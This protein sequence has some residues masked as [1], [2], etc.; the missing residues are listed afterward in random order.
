MI[1]YE[2]MPRMN[3]VRAISTVR[4]WPV[5]LTLLLVGFM[6][7]TASAQKTT[8][9]FSTQEDFAGWTD[10]K[11]G[12]ALLLAPTDRSL[13]QNT[14]NGTGNVNQAG[15][16]GTD[17]A[18]S[19]MWK[20][21]NYNSI[22]SPGQQSNSA[23]IV[24]LGDGKN[25]QI[26]VD[27][28]EP[29]K[30]S[31]TYFSLLL[32]LNY[33]GTW[34]QIKP[35]SVT[36]H[37]AYRTAA[38]DYSFNTSGLSYLSIGFIYASN[39]NSDTPFTVDNIRI[40]D[41]APTSATR[42]MKRTTTSLFTTKEDFTGWSDNKKGES[43]QVVAVDQ[44]LDQQ[45]VNGL[46]NTNHA[47][48]KGQ[49]GA[50]SVTWK[51][52]DYNAF[53]SPGQQNNHALID[54]LGDGT[55]RQIMVDYT[56]PPKGSGTYFSLLLNLNYN[57]HW[58]QI[59]P[60][61]VSDHGTYKTATYDFTFNSAGLSYL[62]VG[63][64]YVSNYNSS[65]PFMI[66]NVRL[67]TMTPDES[68]QDDTP[69]PSIKQDMA[70][71]QG[72]M[73]AWSMTDTW[74]QQTPTRAEV[75]LNGLW[76]F[77]PAFN[78]KLLTQPTADTGWGW[79]KVPGAWPPGN[80]AQQILL[81]SEIND[82]LDQ[83]G[84]KLADMQAA[85]YKRTIQVPAAW[86]GRR[87]L[88][89]FDL[90]QTSGTLYVDGQ[91]A[92]EIK[93]PGGR[94]DITSAIR[95]GQTQEL[96]ILVTAYR[97]KD[98]GTAWFGL[99]NS[100][101]RDNQ[102]KY[103]GLTGDVSLIAEP[104]DNVLGDTHVITS[105]RQHRI[106]FDTAVNPSAE[107]FR[108]NATVF[109]GD[110]KVLTIT[111][112]V[113][114]HKD[115]V[116]GRIKFSGDWA[117]PLLWDL[118]TPQNMYTATIALQSA[119]GRKLLDESTPVSFGFREFWID[120]RDFYLNGS[121]IHLRMLM[122]GSA[123]SN[124]SDQSLEGALMM[125]D[126]A[127]ADGH[128]TFLTT[129]Y[130]FLPGEVGYA[131]N[132]YR[133]T[134]QKGM[135][136]SVSLLNIMSYDWKLD[137]PIIRDQYNQ[138][139][140]YLIKKV[141]NHPSVFAYAM[142][143]N[144][145]VYYDAPNP[146]RLDG[147]YL[148]DGKPGQN[149]WQSRVRKLAIDV[150]AAHAK[151]VDPTRPVYHH[152]AGNLGDMITLNA[153]FNW[154]PIQERSDWF[155]LWSQQGVKPLMLVEYG[156]PHV[157][158][159]TSYRGPDFIWFKPARMWLWDREYAAAFTENDAY[160]M[161]ENE[162][163]S[164][165]LQ[166][167]MLHEKDKFF[168]WDITSYL[169]PQEHNFM[170]LK[171]RYYAINLPA[172]R[173]WGLSGILPW[174]QE[175]SWVM[176]NSDAAPT[177]WP[178]RYANLKQPGIVPDFRMPAKRYPAAWQDSDFRPTS[179]T[180][181]FKR[182]N[183]PL[184]GYIA[185]AAESFTDRVHNIRAGEVVHKQLAVINDARKP[186][187]CHWSWALQG[188]NL[189]ATGRTEVQPGEHAM[190]P[191]EIHLP[192][193]L[194][195]GAYTLK[196]A[197][198]FGNEIVQEDTF[199]L[200][201]ID[202]RPSLAASIRI[203]LFDPSGDTQK[204]L[205]SLGVSAKRFASAGELPSATTLAADFDLLVVGRNALDGQPSLSQLSAI[206]SGLKVLVFE[207][208]EHALNQLGFRTQTLVSRQVFVRDSGHSAL[209]GITNNLLHDWRGDT[210]M[211]APYMQR[212]DLPQEQ[213]SVT[214]LGFKNDRVWRAGNRGMVA[215][216]VI[217]KP[218][219]GNFVP[220]LD[221]GFDL[222]YTPLL[223]YSASGGEGRI[224]FCQLDVT[225]RTQNDPAAENL[226]IQL[227]NDLHNTRTLHVASVFYDGD[228]TGG[229]LLDTLGVRYTPYQGQPLDADALL[230]VGAGASHLSNITAQ[231]QNGASLLAL[232]VTQQQ[233]DQLAPGLVTLK[234][235]RTVPAPLPPNNEPILRAVSNAEVFWRD[236]PILNAITSASGVG[237]DAL[238]IW[239]LGK[240]RIVLCQA[241][242]DLFDGQKD[243][244]V[245]TTYRRNL[246]LVSRLLHNLGATSQCP[247]VA[248]LTQPPA[249]N[250][251]PWLSSYYFQIPVSQDDPY[252]FYPW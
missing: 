165:E 128:N 224:I 95:P 190:V 2:P 68:A 37:G 200:D 131:A 152:A 222:Q 207:Q 71:P 57:D 169:I 11:S 44:D 238:R 201:V 229:K 234:R 38:Y 167:K 9:L 135:L 1:R 52:G 77:Y 160:S 31:G 151:Q 60:I 88:V 139:T 53:K 148:P 69:M 216:V 184:L 127:L 104:M 178:D 29:A 47:G 118:D 129:P 227:I 67:V 122:N 154:A 63:F 170:K 114:F 24:A 158:N 7:A 195:P 149:A 186:I 58:T 175:Q 8:I 33:D 99:G 54:A 180:S 134:D 142:N 132:L 226:T 146:Q 76:R 22:Q 120:G 78:N 196:A 19:V 123:T 98:A 97:A 182:W 16:A 39:Y 145:L 231:V 194:M 218:P 105:V 65:A 49:P 183:Q 23:L 64:I 202:Q 70:A 203:A 198:D 192:Q 133:A 247:L 155:G 51:S 130:G 237:N 41:R 181:V 174:D 101:K 34:T 87:F 137:D 138:L 199:Q 5:L 121:K 147:I 56:E 136:V 111:S 156:L 14:T 240:G 55:N 209:A 187:V 235:Q 193:S 215:S 205:Q 197:F 42:A 189:S 3:S 61:S 172:F 94:V 89:N 45:A 106:T 18:L 10:N 12:A 81:P 213:P 35:A 162:L 74:T 214:W 17:G 143:H 103:R 107:S 245:R 249:D 212:P 225:G 221:C 109:H 113:L 119:D 48:A 228:Q 66:D 30:G 15:A 83:I 179:M 164:M 144:G 43:M 62:E 21:G 217:E 204:Y 168:I 163:R 4:F 117:N 36:D 241:T 239:N 126:H 75:S 173:T 20:S 211:V 110:E 80:P 108:L 219:I 161:D 72:V 13:D 59:K 248:L 25:K 159:W 250:T 244:Y 46:G 191:L 153:Y 93:W 233:M 27:Y 112:P 116:D 115:L 32:N 230:V 140:D 96:S 73:D 171:A 223:E 102:I 86:K 206:S 26:L 85:W 232:G 220:L 166:L 92:G 91:P 208:S 176:T 79:F 82:F 50:L 252:R 124:A 242:P 236:L 125:C 188:T 150:A 84:W 28:T 141:W 246:F 90:I 243:A 210:T 40:V 185:G 251:S 6:G 177:P 157:A 100:V